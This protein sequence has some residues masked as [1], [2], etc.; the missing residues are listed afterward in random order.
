MAYPPLIPYLVVSD[1]ASAIDFY[2]SAFGAIELTRHNA[3]DSA[4]ISHAHL[5][6]NGGSIMLS[7]DF[8]GMMGGK[9]MIPE[10]LGGSPITLHLVL[11][12][13]DAFWE[14]A[15]AAGA[16][17]KMELADQFW[18]DRYGQLTDPFGHIWSLGEQKAQLSDE[19]IAEAAKEFFNPKL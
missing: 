7:D 5:L 4:Q 8:S 18:G 16:E 2:K 10:A 3:G 6:I 1:A 14:R 13:V 19:Q 9:S 12:D 15:V 17:V 11:A